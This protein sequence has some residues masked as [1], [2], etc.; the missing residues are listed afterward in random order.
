MT[1]APTSKEQTDKA[2]LLPPTPLHYPVNYRQLAA[3]AGPMDGS[4]WRSLREK[5]VKI[6]AL[7]LGCA[8]NAAL[9]DATFLLLSKM[10]LTYGKSFDPW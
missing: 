10:H 7:A 9:S 2:N 6:E 8:T 4:G 1:A 3:A 5:K